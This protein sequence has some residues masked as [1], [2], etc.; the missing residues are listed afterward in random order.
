MIW[1]LLACSQ[2]GID[3]G[4]QWFGGQSGSESALTDFCDSEDIGDTNVD[5]E[6]IP[7]TY[8]AD[9]EALLVD[10]E[11]TWNGTLT[12]TDQVETLTSTLS[13]D[14]NHTVTFMPDSDDCLPYYRVPAT[15][16]MDSDGALAETVDGHLLLADSGASLFYGS[17]DVFNI[18]GTISPP[19]GADVLQFASDS[20][21]NG[22]MS[23]TMT[24]ISNTLSDVAGTWSVS[25][26]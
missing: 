14:P 5:S 16:T 20:I 22:E 8:N 15:L 21:L 7:G 12:L 3:T 10:I 4:P 2:Q 11:G 23:G 24:W 6:A 26:E 25:Q 1:L 9:A 18:E 17:V 13:G 19:D